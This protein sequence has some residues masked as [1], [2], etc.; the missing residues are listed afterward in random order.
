MACYP[1]IPY[2]IQADLISQLIGWTRVGNFTAVENLLDT[3]EATD[4]PKYGH[5]ALHEAL[6]YKQLDLLRYLIT[7]GFDVNQKGP[8]AYGEICLSPLHF[9]AEGNSA[10]A[11]DILLDAG[12]DAT[13]DD[14]AAD[15]SSMRGVFPTGEDKGPHT[16]F[17]AAAVWGSDVAVQ[18]LIDRLPPGTIADHEWPLALSVAALYRQP[19][20]LA[21][22]LRHYPAPGVP[23]AI[24][25]RALAE[26]AAMEDY[27]ADLSIFMPLATESWQRGLETVRLLLAYGARPNPPLQLPR[28]IYR[29]KRVEPGPII[30]TVVETSMGMEMLRMLL[31]HGL[32]L[33]EPSFAGRE[34]EPSLFARAVNNGNPDLI[35]FFYEHQAAV[36]DINEELPETHLWTGG[37]LLHAA[38]KNG[39]LE[40][41]QFLLD[42]GADPLQLNGQGWLPIH[43]ACQQRHFAVIELLWPCSSSSP[44]IPDLANYRTQDGNTAFHLAHCWGTADDP[45]VEALSM[46][47]F[48]FFKDKGADLSSLDSH[49]KSILHYVP[50][51]NGKRFCAMMEA[52]V[53]LRPDSQG[54]T[55]LHLTMRRPDWELRD[56]RFLL[57]QGATKDINAQ[58]N[59]GRTPLYF[60]LE[61]HRYNPDQ[62]HADR[63]IRS[64]VLDFLIEAGA[65]ADIPAASGKTAREV[66]EAKGFPYDFDKWKAT[67]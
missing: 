43:Q 62:K 4:L 61:C 51:F 13:V 28:S 56:V 15:G 58:D 8:N 27:N 1:R 44:T 2:H 32:E 22:L 39:R 9:A 3:P 49:G 46:R 6:R 38:A 48:Y 45:E 67:V 41:V 63:Q 19:K 36:L 53:R 29:S 21:I 25:D 17:M 35:H 59:K 60:Y 14:S 66:A 12:A 16:P 7:R 23:Q 31:D 52:G 65:D 34:G 42:H 37:S 64:V 18:R 55:E 30:E 33:P 26:A 20:T 47:L 10:E 57:T 54:Q 11:V 5:T 40:T 50:F 24:L